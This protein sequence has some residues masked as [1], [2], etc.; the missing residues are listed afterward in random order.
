MRDLA[1]HSND[2]SNAIS[3]QFGCGGEGRPGETAFA[4]A[5]RVGWGIT[6]AQPRC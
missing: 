2:A 6:N 1:P 3:Y 4:T 5:M